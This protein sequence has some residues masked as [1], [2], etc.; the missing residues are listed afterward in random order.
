M[1]TV[2][3]MRR[4]LVEICDRNGGGLDARRCKNCAI[5]LSCWDT[6]GHMPRN[7][8]P[9]AIRRLYSAY[10]AKTVE[11]GGNKYDS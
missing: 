2:E 3:Q 5:R 6:D 8:P 7:M 1:L 9:E 10:I 4:E 11:R